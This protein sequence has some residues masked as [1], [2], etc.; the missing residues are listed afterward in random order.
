MARIPTY[1]YVLLGAGIAGLI[2]S[3]MRDLTGTGN[4]LTML[5]GI[6]SGIV[7]LGTVLVMKYDYM[8]IPFIQQRSRTITVP[9]L[10]RYELSP[11]QDTII[12]TEGN[13]YYASAFLG[14]E[15]YRSPTEEVQEENLKNNEFFERAISSFRYVTKIGYIVHVEEIAQMINDLAKKRA[16]AQAKLVHERQK[17]GARERQLLIEKYSREVEVW[18]KQI[19]K[20]TSGKTMGVLVYAMITAKSD[21][22]DGAT[23]SAKARAEEIRIALSNS[24]NIRAELLRGDRLLKCFEWERMYP[25]TTDE[26]E[27]EA[28]SMV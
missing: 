26:L 1:V 18:E 16:E 27:A 12:R 17:P 11:A 25:T 2:L 19:K 22:R 14:I 13:A 24:L 20:I 21:S 6:I 3:T 10:G 23:V 8:A 5:G 9:D 28:V 4:I 15:V 7:A